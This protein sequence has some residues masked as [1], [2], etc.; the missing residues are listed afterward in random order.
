MHRLHRLASAARPSRSLGTG[1][2]NLP[3]SHPAALPPR[4]L[5]SITCS[6]E[7]SS[8]RPGGLLSDA[9]IFGN[10]DADRTVMFGKRP[11]GAEI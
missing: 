9:E 3:N 5:C 10:L 4:L 7:E 6:T 8:H 1:T 11:S 2:V